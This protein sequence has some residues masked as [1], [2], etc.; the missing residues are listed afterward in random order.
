MAQGLGLRVWGLGFGVWV[1]G[2]GFM[3]QGSGLRFQ[4]SGIT[5]VPSVGSA[6]V[7]PFCDRGA[8]VGFRLQGS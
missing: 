8:P 7:V 3:V 2:L 4:V 6:G 1:Y 5:G